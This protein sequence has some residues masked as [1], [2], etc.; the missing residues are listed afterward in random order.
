VLSGLT[1]LSNRLTSSALFNWLV[2]GGG[3]VLNKD[4]DFCLG[5][6]V[7][8][9]LKSREPL[10]YELGDASD[11]MPPMFRPLVDLIDE[12]KVSVQQVSDACW[13]AKIDYLKGHTILECVARQL[14]L[15]YMEE[16]RQKMLKMASYRLCCDEDRKSFLKRASDSEL[17]VRVIEALSS[18]DGKAI[19]EGNE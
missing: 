11:V 1:K 7:G 3:I 10:P 13:H 9:S 2:H 14:T 12:E 4:Y 6:L 19:A 15:K 8:A 17:K 5:L 16:L 18:P